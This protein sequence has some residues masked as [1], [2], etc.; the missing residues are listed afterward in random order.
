[1]KRLLEMFPESVLI[2]SEAKND[3]ENKIWS[4]RQF[5]Q[6][7]YDAKQKKR[8]LENINVEVSTI[9]DKE[10]IDSN[11]FSIIS[12]FDFIKEQEN[13]TEGE[14]YSMNRNIQIQ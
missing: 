4:N 9:I 1:M 5:R 12:L 8:N 10:D 6:N 2:T 7:I 13:Q 3:K 11:S 14:I